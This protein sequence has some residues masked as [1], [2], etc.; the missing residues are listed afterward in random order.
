MGIR[1][2]PHGGTHNTSDNFPAQEISFQDGVILH[3]ILLCRR[4]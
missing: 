1:S 3:C 2:C 4:V